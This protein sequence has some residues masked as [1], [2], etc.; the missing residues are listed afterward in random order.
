[1]HILLDDILMNGEAD[2]ADT[3]FWQDYQSNN[4]HDKVKKKISWIKS[5]SD[6]LIKKEITLNGNLH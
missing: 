5:D 6:W 2:K 1:I 4:Y 3:V